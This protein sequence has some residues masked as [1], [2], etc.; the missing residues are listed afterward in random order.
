MKKISIVTIA[1]VSSLA[2]FGCA[3]PIN[4]P[5]PTQT[6]SVYESPSAINTEPPVS[7]THP[8]TTE[9][10]SEPSQATQSPA[11][12]P[13]SDAAAPPATQF[14]QRW[15]KTYPS[16]PEYQILRAANSTCELIGA[17]GNDWAHDPQIKAGL[18]AI[19][20]NADMKASDAQEFAQDA[21]QNYCASV[22]NP[23]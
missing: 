23:T 21:S 10:E 15:G 4:T 6:P 9:P 3:K 16:V 20:T 13:T 17:S 2:F 19:M 12:V 5:T 11:D 14:A 18:E 1:I 8:A 22:A 7:P